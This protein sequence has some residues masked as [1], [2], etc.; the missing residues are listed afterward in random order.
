MDETLRRLGSYTAAKDSRLACAAAVILSEL[1]PKDSGLVTQLIAALEHAD[2]VRRPFIIEAL[3]RIGTADAAAALVPLIKSE[4]PAS[5]QALRAI[6]HTGSA[7]LKPLLKMLGSISP[8]LLEKVAECAARTS[9]STAYQALLSRLENADIDTCRAIRAGLRTAMTTLEDRA[10]DNLRRQLEK[11][12]RV[13][14]LTRHAPAVIALMKIAGDLGD[15]NLLSFIQPRVAADNP[16]NVR[17]AALLAIGMLHLSGDQRARLAP[18]ILP[19]LLDADVANLAE[20]ALE[21]L[22]QANLGADHQTG[23]RKLLNS[24]SP[25]IREFAMRTLASTGTTRTL[26]ELIGCLDSPDRSMRE[27]ALGALSRA[28]SASAA[29]A[30]RLLDSKGGESALETARALAPQAAHIPPRMLH[31]LAEE[32]IDTG[33]HSTRKVDADTL[34]RQEDKRRSILSVFRGANSPILVESA[35]ERAKK[36]QQKGENQQAY[37]LLRSIQ[38]LT[39]WS[40]EHKIHTALAGLINGPKDLARTARTN[41]PHLRA[42]EDILGSGRW[43]VKDLSKIVLK[44]TDLN[45]KSLYYLGFHFVE[46]MHVERQFGKAVLEHLMAIRSDEGRQAKEK[47]VIEGLLAV[48]GGNANILEQRAK[49][50]MAASDMKAAAAARSTPSP[51]PKKQIK[52]G[53]KK[54]RQRPAKKKSGGGKARKKR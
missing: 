12:F 46:R 24:Q 26:T 44:D 48:K 43:S 35:A 10:K 6:A 38:G 37:E 11:S 50:L 42:L 39:G 19:L 30:E 4:G 49:V 34:R 52:L 31:K 36:L 54:N 51:K 13:S 41:D 17:R 21:A 25:R 8:Q 9:E 16:P 53:A 5:D 40:D 47:L 22:R 1:A 45:K 3:G 32:Y 28:P 14:T 20:P 27:E 2:A 7:A 15:P 29:L 23:L 33:K 18:K